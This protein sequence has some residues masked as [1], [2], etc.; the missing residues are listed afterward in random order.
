MIKGWQYCKDK[1]YEDV[2]NSYQC[3][4]A[5]SRMARNRSSHTIQIR[6]AI[7]SRKH[8]LPGCIYDRRRS[9]QLLWNKKNK[10]QPDKNVEEWCSKHK[11]CKRS[12]RI[13][14]PKSK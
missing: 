13:C 9:Q 4:N 11:T 5:L 10:K 7:T 1:G 12:S 8:F 3:R 14:V 2:R 6:F